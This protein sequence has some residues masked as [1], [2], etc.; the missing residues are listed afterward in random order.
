MSQPPPNDEAAAISAPQIHL[1]IA[2]EGDEKKEEAAA[3]ESV[4]KPDSHGKTA[5]TA[6]ATASIV[7]AS[8]PS[9]PIP[10]AVTTPTPIR[11][12]ATGSINPFLATVP[13]TAQVTRKHP[14]ILTDPEGN[15]KSF[16]SALGL[17]TRKFVNLIHVR[18]LLHFE[19][20]VSMISLHSSNT[21]KDSV[22]RI[23]H[24]PAS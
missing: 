6:V 3:G 20:T 19:C 10:T 17:L 13:V 18:R 24:S 5:P 9:V 16:G 21:E 1:K 14:F 2:A 12:H 4:E 22:N 11:S 7:P 15:E 23:T 8:V